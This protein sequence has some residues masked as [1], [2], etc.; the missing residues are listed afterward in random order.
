MN[1]YPIGDAVNI[2]VVFTDHE[3]GTAISVAGISLSLQDPT[4]VVEIYSP[5]TTPAIANPMT[6][7][8]SLL[9]APAVPGVW[10]YRWTGTSPVIA[11]DGEFEVAPSEFVPT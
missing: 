5:M 7:R 9:L 8:Y 1:T 2:K 3:T 4:G 10:K 6:G 11:Q